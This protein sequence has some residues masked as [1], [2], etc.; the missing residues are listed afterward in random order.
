MGSLEQR[1]CS[2]GAFLHGAVL[3]HFS[4]V[5]SC[6]VGGQLSL[7]LERDLRQTDKFEHWFVCLFVL[8]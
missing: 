7:S 1:A 5:P 4:P 2:Y 3:N 6:E 8:F